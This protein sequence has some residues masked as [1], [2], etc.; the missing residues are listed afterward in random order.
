MRDQE[1]LDTVQAGIERD[2]AR[3]QQARVVAELQERFM[4]LASRE[5]EVLRIVVAG[6]QNKEIA[7]E[8][9]LSEMTVKV[10]RSQVMR[11]MRARSLVDLVRMTD[12]LGVSTRKS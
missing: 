8:L 5:R 12:T 9:N 4:S 7:H 2:R 3:R 10:H 1:L 11:Q 6:R